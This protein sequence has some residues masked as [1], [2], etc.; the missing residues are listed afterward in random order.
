M[1]SLP[2]SK[3]LII[4]DGHC[5]LCDYWVRLLL[6]HDKKEV[7][8]FTELQ[9][10]TGKSLQKYL[11]IENQNVDSII[12]YIPKKTYYLKSIAIFEIVKS[13]P[14]YFYGV[15]IFTILPQFITDKMYTVIA[16]NR[17]R[18]FGLKTTCD[19]IDARMQHRF[20]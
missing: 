20:I 16:K 9:S 17:Y 1:I 12:L 7:F 2:D 15:L 13:L 11:G 8:Y 18:W 19:I 10:E 3:K 5:V 4:Y 6:R 14:W